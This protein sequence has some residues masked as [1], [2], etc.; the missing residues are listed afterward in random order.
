MRFSRRQFLR[1]AGVSL[2]LPALDAF[3][4]ARASASADRE[5][6]RMVCI[7]APLGFYPPNFIPEQAGRN[8][9]PTTHL[10]LLN[11]FRND[12]T[13][14]SGLMHTGNSPGF[15]HQA[16][17]SFLT[18]AEG[19]GRPGFRN[20]ISLDQFAAEQIGEQTRFPTLTLSSEGLGLAWT[21][22]GAQI[23]ADN[24]PARVFARLF[25]KG[26]DDEVHTQLKRLEEGRS[27]LDD[28]RG[29]AADLRSF[30][31]V[32]DREK[33]D[34]YMTSV[35]DLER[36]LHNEELWCK[37]PKPAVD[38]APPLDIANASDLIGR[39][40]LLFDLTHLA[41]QT[42]ST[43]L[44]TIMLQGS[45]KAPPISGVSLGHHD[46]SH[47]GKDPKKLE[48]LQIVEVETMK[49]IRDLLAKFKQS[50]EDDSNLL[51]RTTI[52]LGSNL[53]DASSHSVKNLPVLLAGGGFRHGQH[54]AF[55][56]DAPPPLCNLYVSMLQRL[57]IE[58]GGFSNATGTLT[59]L[60]T[61]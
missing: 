22:T 35:R 5:K 10:E 48:Q 3:T 30:L 28:V 59:G 51:E 17:A 24:S 49:T 45:T 55:D 4:P 26:A 36:S 58:T 13:V 29:Q 61:A 19:A 33:L 1:A 7:C 54:L 60:E 20:S 6:R 32:N 34:E 56:P 52:F 42:D 8:Y 41:L 43:R 31:G 18:G 9:E 2:A 39:T 12:F 23:P 15:A 27:I 21:R 44:V 38:A 53:G 14:I 40:K 16:T 50:Q 37:R 57:G 47:H 11:D 46:L 25:L